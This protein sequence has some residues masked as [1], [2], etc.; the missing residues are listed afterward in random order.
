MYSE[1]YEAMKV[2]LAQRWGKKP[3]RG[4][5]KKH[6]DDDGE[7]ETK[8]KDTSTTNGGRKTN[9]ARSKPRNGN[10]IQHDLDV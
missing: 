10:K 4:K 5:K 8:K 1:L 3:I 7:G 9:D 6:G 2:R